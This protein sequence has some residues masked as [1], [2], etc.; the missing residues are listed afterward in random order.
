MSPEEVEVAR[1]AEQLDAIKPTWFECVDPDI[2]FSRKNGEVKI[3]C[4]DNCVLDQTFA[5][6][7]VDNDPRYHNGFGYANIILSD[8]YPDFNVSAGEKGRA[9]WPADLFDKGQESFSLGREVWRAEIDKR[10]AAA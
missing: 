4:Y 5:E 8:R 6:D 2:L 10:R 3:D 1:V 9:F 7:S